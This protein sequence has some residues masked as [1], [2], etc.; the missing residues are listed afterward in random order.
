MNTLRSRTFGASIAVVLVLLLQAAT[1]RASGERDGDGGRRVVITFTKWM[2]NG[3][4]LMEGVVG[5]DVAGTFAGEVL[6]GLTTANQ[7]ITLLDA[8]Y[9]VRAGRRSFTALMHGGEDNQQAAAILEGVVLAG[10]QTGA[11]VQVQFHDLPTC[12]GNP[13]GPCFQGTITIT[14]DREN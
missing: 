4:P 1:L 12:A 13:A 9:E 7:Q 14:P 11:R 8:V 3:G 10:W 6:L 5:G 2:I